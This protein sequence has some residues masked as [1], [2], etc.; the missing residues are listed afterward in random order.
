MFAWEI[1]HPELSS[2]NTKNKL[3]ST[4]PHRKKHL[5]CNQWTNDSQLCNIATLPCKI[6]LNHIIRVINNIKFLSLFT[7]FVIITWWVWQARLTVRDK[8]IYAFIFCDCGQ[9]WVYRRNKVCLLSMFVFTSRKYLW[10][11]IEL[12]YREFFL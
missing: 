11:F 9:M 3:I 6:L 5:L 1:C 10:S 2:L 8:Y 4:C 12:K 7:S